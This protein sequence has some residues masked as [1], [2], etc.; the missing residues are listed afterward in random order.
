MG[1]AAAGYRSVPSNAFDGKRLQSG[2]PLPGGSNSSGSD[3]FAEDARAQLGDM[4]GA[5]EGRL[6]PG[7]HSQRMTNNPIFTPFGV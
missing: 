3:N 4:M 2:K 6:G 7:L 1:L 5:L